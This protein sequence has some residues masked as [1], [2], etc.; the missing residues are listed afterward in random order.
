MLCDAGAGGGCSRLASANRA[1]AVVGIA[2]TGFAGAGEGTATMVDVVG[3]VG[4]VRFVAHVDILTAAGVR[5]TNV[6]CVELDLM[7]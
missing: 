7:G 1:S 5:F 4:V 3:V 2:T 6:L